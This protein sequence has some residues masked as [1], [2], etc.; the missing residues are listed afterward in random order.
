MDHNGAV[1]VF[2]AEADGLLGFE[3]DDEVGGGVGVCG[4]AVPDG[5]G[6]AFVKGALAFAFRGGKSFLDAFCL[7]V[8]GV[9]GAG[10]GQGT[11]V[12]QDLV[13]EHHRLASIF[14]DGRSWLWGLHYLR[15][16][17]F[18]LGLR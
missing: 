9:C 5:E 7:L 18:T 10:Q 13:H 1:D 6:E 17:T 2:V 4:C 8:V 12:W 15:S 3:A 14:L 11:G 16:N